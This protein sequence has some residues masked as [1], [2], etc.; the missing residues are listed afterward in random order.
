MSNYTRF[1]PKIL[2]LCLGES[3]PIRFEKNLSK[4]HT[5]NT[6]IEITINVYNKPATIGN[7]PAMDNIHIINMTNAINKRKSMHTIILVLLY[8]YVNYIDTFS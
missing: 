2:L 4:I 1:D 6:I 3:I 5:S 8:L 7:T